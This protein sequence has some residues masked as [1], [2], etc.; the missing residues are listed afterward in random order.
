MRRHFRFSGRWLVA[1]PPERVAEVLV[2]LAEYPCWWPEVRAVASLGPDDARVLC[3]SRLPYTLDLLLHAESRTVPELR[4]AVDGDLRGRV[5]WR[6]LPGG[7]EDTWLELEQEVEVVGRL[8]AAVSPVAAPLM[9][10]NH[11]Q[12]M[13]GGVSGLRAR[14]R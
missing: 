12:M 7:H 3:R 14:L 11:A 6:L 10:W 4:V 1:S 13:R 5:G 2:D 9:R 8:L